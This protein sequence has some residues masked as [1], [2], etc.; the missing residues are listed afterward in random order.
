M[1]CS[2]VTSPGLPP[3]LPCFPSPS[4][5]STSPRRP[6]AGATASPACTRAAPA[7]RQAGAR[8]GTSRSSSS[9]PRLCLAS[10]KSSVSMLSDSYSLSL[11]GA[12]SRRAVRRYKRGRGLNRR[13]LSLNGNCT[14]NMMGKL[15]SP[16]R[17]QQH[18]Q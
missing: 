11:T 6:A 13:W 8:T 12:S 18:M 4:S 15:F 9:T 16:V 17:D 1:T 7:V 2:D 14:S 3:A 5:P 10:F